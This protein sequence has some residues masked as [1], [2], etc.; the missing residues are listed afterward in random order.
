MLSEGTICLYSQRG[1]V[2]DVRHYNNPCHRRTL[3]KRWELYYSRAFYSCYVQISP[4]VDCDLVKINGENKK[5]IRHQ[6]VR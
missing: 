5:W 3:I 1:E 2:I 4:N 6:M